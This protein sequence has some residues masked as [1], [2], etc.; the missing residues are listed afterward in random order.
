VLAHKIRESLI[1]QRNVEP[2]S[3]EIHM[4]GAYVNGY[5][6]PQNKKEDRIDR[7]LA[8][9]QRPDKRC[10][11]VMRQKSTDADM[12]GANKTLTFIK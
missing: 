7:R 3:G 10:V 11:F 2:L 9:H 12:A 6:R 5:I 4:D 8:E 1:E